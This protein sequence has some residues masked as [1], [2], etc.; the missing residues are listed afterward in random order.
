MN[1]PLKP[2]PTWLREIV[3]DRS[4]TTPPVEQ[5][6]NAIRNK[7]AVGQLKATEVMPS[8]RTMARQVGTTPAT[9]SRTY[10]LLQREGLLTTQSGLGTTVADLENLQQSA[11]S[12]ILDAAGQVL[13]QAMSSLSA[14]GVGADELEALLR[15]RAANSIR[16]L[17]VVF[18]ARVHTNMPL[19]DRQ[20]RSTFRGMPVEVECIALERLEQ[21]EPAAQ[22]AVEEADII[23]SLVT[24]KRILAEV[25]PQETEVRYLIAEVVMDAA[26]ALSNLPPDTEIA[27]VAG[28]RFRTVA[29]GMLHTYGAPE[30]ITVVRDIYDEDALRAI[31]RD[32]VVVRTFQHKDRIGALLPEHQLIC[33]DFEL[34]ADSLSRLREFA[35]SVLDVQH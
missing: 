33:I 14:L 16:P 26:E 27:L 30:R 1:K 12:G 18:I 25:L 10:Q 7:I 19:Y 5:I 2:E 31:P 17:R 4:D 20:L 29:L 23:T 34:R 28:E 15:S 3:V 32:V 21:A 24:Y 22:A 8:V 9:V 11:R 6:A 13:D 35:A